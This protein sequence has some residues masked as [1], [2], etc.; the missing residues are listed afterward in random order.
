MLKKLSAF[1]YILYKSD[2]KKCFSQLQFFGGCWDSNQFPTVYG[3][4]GWEGAFQKDSPEAITTYDS[5][6]NWAVIATLD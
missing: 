6:K 4:K 3:P 2:E 5:R 1:L